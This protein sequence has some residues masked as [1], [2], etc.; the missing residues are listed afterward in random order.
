VKLMLNLLAGLALLASGIGPA[1]GAINPSHSGG[2]GELSLQAALSLRSDPV[3]CPAGTPREADE[4]FSRSGGG[5]VPGLGFVVEAYTFIVDTNSPSCTD[6]DILYGTNGTLTVAGKGAIDVVLAGPPECFLPALAV[7]KAKRSFTIT[8]G[9]G[10]YVGASGSGMLQHDLTAGT[11][12]GSA[13]TDTWVGTL[14]VPGHTFD[15]TAPVISGAVDKTVRAP[16]G[17][18]KARVPYKVTA[19][20]AVDGAVPV[21]CRPP[22]RSLFKLGRTTVKCST[23]DKSGNTATAAFK[24]TVRR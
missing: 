16:R 5:V 3:A 13:G 15:L 18:K 19:R 17:K 8:G 14:A 11:T 24:V 20:D 2:L 1:A 4:C 9:T 22:P 10:I 12:G 6:G 7:L 21:A 23:V